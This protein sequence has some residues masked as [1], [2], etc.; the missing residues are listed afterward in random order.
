MTVRKFEPVAVYLV[1]RGSDAY[2]DNRET[3]TLVFNTACLYEDIKNPLALKEFYRQYTNFQ[4][5]TFNYSP[6]IYEIA[7]TNG[8]YAFKSR[9]FDLRIIDSIENGRESITFLTY[10]ANAGIAV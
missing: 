4:K 5:L 1:T 6:K 8:Q 7:L 9:G 3:L 10:N 2:S